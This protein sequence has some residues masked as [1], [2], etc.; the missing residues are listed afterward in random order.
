MVITFLRLT[1]ETLGKHD[2]DLPGLSPDLR[3]LSEPLT[4]ASGLGFFFRSIKIV[5][6]KIWKI[7]A[8]DL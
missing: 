8:R 5:V 3:R 1:S 7:R 2:F 6:L 4:F